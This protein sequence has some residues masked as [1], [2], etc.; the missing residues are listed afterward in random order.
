MAD[1]KEAAELVELLQT[2]DNLQAPDLKDQLRPSL[3]GQYNKGNQ[4]AQFI[5]N[6]ADGEP[7]KGGGVEGSDSENSAAG[8]EAQ[9]LESPSAQPGQKSTS[10]TRSMSSIPKSD[11]KQGV[12]R[13]CWFEGG[14][15]PEVQPPLLSFRPLLSDVSRAC[16]A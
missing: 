11:F 12:I 10:L 6:I 13:G 4:F 2:A 5:M 14:L 16:S 15:F 7:W 1:K 3:T 8:A 9:D